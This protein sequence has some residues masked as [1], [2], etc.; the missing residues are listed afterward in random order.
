MASQWPCRAPSSTL[1][2]GM[3]EADL[4]NGSLYDVLRGAYGMRLAD[5][6]STASA[7]LAA[8]E[9]AALLKVEMP[10]A[11]LAVEQITYLHSGQPVEFVRSL[12]RGDRYHMQPASRRHSK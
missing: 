11:L 6:E 3:M 8:P 4:E 12:Y 10:A 2:P 5:G 9:D 1:F 7:E